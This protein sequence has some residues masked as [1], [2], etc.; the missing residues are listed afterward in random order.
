MAYKYAAPEDHMIV[1]ALKKGRS[2]QRLMI[3]DTREHEASRLAWWMT[4]V[5]WDS[6]LVYASL[7]T[8]QRTLHAESP[9]SVKKSLRVIVK[10]WKLFKRTDDG[11]YTPRYKPKET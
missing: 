1:E 11:K 2:L 9:Q 6:G 10:D 5:S 7:E 8:M 4:N 3:G